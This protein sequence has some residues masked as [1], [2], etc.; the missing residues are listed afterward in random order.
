VQEAAPE[1]GCQLVTLCPDPAVGLTSADME[2]LISD[3]DDEPSP[4][5]RSAI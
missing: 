3:S 2:G 1:L 5:V 4:T